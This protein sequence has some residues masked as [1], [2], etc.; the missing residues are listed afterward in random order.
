MVV[1]MLLAR[2]IGVSVDRGQAAIKLLKE[3][4]ASRDLCQDVNI[5]IRASNLVQ[6]ANRRKTARR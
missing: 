1:M 4:T 5:A 3:D 2:V 6:P